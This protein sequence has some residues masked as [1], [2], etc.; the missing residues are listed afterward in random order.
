M[1][2]NRQ[3]NKFVNIIGII[4]ISISLIL[5][6]SSKVID[7][8]KITAPFE[9][10]VKGTI[11]GDWIDEAKEHEL[12]REIEGSETPAQELAKNIKEF[13]GLSKAQQYYIKYQGLMENFEGKIAEI[14]NKFLI[15][16][17][18]LLLF[19]SKSM[20][21][22]IPIT[23]TCIVTALI[24]PFEV[25]IVINSIGYLLIF[26]IKYFW[27]RYIDAGYIHRLVKN[28]KTLLKYIQDEENG[29]AT[30]NPLL[31]FILRLV[32][33]VPINPISAMYGHMGYDY[34]KYIFLSMLGVSLK[35]VSFTA[36]GSNISDPFSSAFVIP[37]IVI[38]FVSGF[39]MISFSVILN[40]R[41]KREVEKVMKELESEIN[42]KD[43]EIPE[44]E[45]KAP[46]EEK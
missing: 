27:G 37:L 22:L 24:F 30:G 1:G 20:I 11:V 2:R 15:F 36:L 4:L 6:Y 23:I 29:Y 9:Q 44:E 7:F 3:S 14:P 17:C 10:A 5:A 46:D 40:R 39:S 41:E 42:L 31:L 18:L 43:F 33:T 28:S 34:W 35:I 25:A 19:T 26:T 32:P 38:L 45:I 13:T 21:V 16:I 12:E 8:D